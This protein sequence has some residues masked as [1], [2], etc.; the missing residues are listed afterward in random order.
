MCSST[1]C[2][3]VLKLSVGVLSRAHSVMY[4]HR[5][6]SARKNSQFYCLPDL[7]DSQHNLYLVVFIDVINDDAFPRS[8]NDEKKRLFVVC[9][10]GPS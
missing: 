1:V 5:V 9:H 7:T 4:T 8:N 6:T 3:Q 10:F 2:S